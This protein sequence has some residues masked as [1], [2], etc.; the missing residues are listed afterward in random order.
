[1]WIRGRLPFKYPGS[2]E[3][4][5]ALAGTDDDPGLGIHRAEPDRVLVDY[6][7]ANVAKSLHVGHLRTAAIGES[8]KRRI[9]G[10]TEFLKPTN[11]TFD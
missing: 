10:F 8:I 9:G 3:D 2:R 11:F 1:M 4:C 5:E 6:G 7:G